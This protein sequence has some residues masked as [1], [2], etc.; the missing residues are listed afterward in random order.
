MDET[1]TESVEP[2]ENEV[3]RHGLMKLVFGS[4]AAIIVTGLVEKSIDTIAERRHDKKSE[5]IETTEQ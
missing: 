5:T 3:P 1:V 2:V 4:I